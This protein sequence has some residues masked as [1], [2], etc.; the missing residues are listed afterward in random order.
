MAN[1]VNVPTNTTEALQRQAARGGGPAELP[2][3]PEP[4]GA[5][6]APGGAAEAVPA[7]LDIIRSLD[8]ATRKTLWDEIKVEFGYDT[9]TGEQVAPEGGPAGPPG[10]PP[11]APGG[12]PPAAPELE[13]PPGGGY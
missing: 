13:G 2:V 7:I 5:P 10:V 3:G 8:D 11:G 9:M 1:D 4:G 12:A 6:G